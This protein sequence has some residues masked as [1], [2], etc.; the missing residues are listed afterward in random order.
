M[1]AATFAMSTGADGRTEATSKVRSLAAAVAA[2]CV[3]AAGVDATAGAAADAAPCPSAAGAATAIH[4]VT[5]SIT[6]VAI[7]NPP[8]LTLRIP[9]LTM[10]L[11]IPLIFFEFRL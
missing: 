10:T 6:T 2:G 5:A 11:P 7:R 3:A 1:S 9:A 8:K 4:A